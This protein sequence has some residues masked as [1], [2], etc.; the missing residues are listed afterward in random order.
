MSMKRIS[1]IVNV[2]AIVASAVTV[3][4]QARPNF[5]GRWTVDPPPIPAARIDTAD[6]D[7]G[8][9]G[10]GGRGG[11]GGWGGPNRTITITQDASKL[12]VAYP[13]GPNN[14]TVIY[15]FTGAETKNTV[16]GNFGPV[17]QTS[18]AA[19]QG[20]TLVITTGEQT[21]SVSIHNE[22]LVVETRT[23]GAGAGAAAAN[24]ATYT[25]APDAPSRGRGRGGPP[26]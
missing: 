8:G 15:D 4:A 6:N 16:P 14:V 12:T 7:E 9:R 21:R 5:A 10:R 13:Q 17:E 24:R 19:W 20:D 22:K 25:R 11:G 3:S 2:A 23:A 26:R 1:A 18:R